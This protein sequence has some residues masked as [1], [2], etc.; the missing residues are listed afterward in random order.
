MQETYVLTELQL[1]VMRV[2]WR[3]GEATVASVHS[4]LTEQR[5]LATTTVAT[6]LKRLEARGLLTHRTEGRQFLYSALVS[7]DEVRR[8][9]VSELTEH[10][11][12][13]D[14]T[15]LMSHLL[16]ARQ[17]EAGDIEQVRAM[18]DAFENAD[19]TTGE[20]R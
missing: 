17:M 13:G 18:I 6:L 2:L 10:L 4:A 5:E 7:E 15:A 8:S 14:V 9:M 1:A 20:A 19:E 16:N 3:E 11:F 12:A